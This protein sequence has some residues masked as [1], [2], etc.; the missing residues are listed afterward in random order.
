MEQEDP[1]LVAGVVEGI[2]LENAAAPDPDHLQIAKEKLELCRWM[3][4][5][6]RQRRYIEVGVRGRRNQLLH[7]VCVGAAL[8]LLHGN[9]ISPPRPAVVKKGG[10]QG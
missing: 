9:H 10:K 4:G 1:G 6:E 2:I 5:G 3:G 7:G 8:K